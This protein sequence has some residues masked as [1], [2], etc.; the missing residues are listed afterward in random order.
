MPLHKIGRVGIVFYSEWEAN[1]VY[2]YL[3]YVRTDG[4][5]Y[6]C[7]AEH[8]SDEL[9]KPKDGADSTFWRVVVDNSTTKLELLQNIDEKLET[10]KAELRAYISE[11][12]A[13]L[14]KAAI[15]D[16]LPDT[17][18]IG[19]LYLV[20]NGGS[21]DNLYDEY[22]YI[23][24]G[25]EAEPNF[26]FEKLGSRQVEV[27]LDGHYDK[28]EID[29]ML[30]KMPKFA[31][32]LPNPLNVTLDKNQEL[33]EF[34]FSSIGIGGVESVSFGEQNWD[35]TNEYVY[36][37][38]QENKV[39]RKDYKA[40][41][42]THFVF[43][44]G[45]EKTTNLN[46]FKFTIEP[47]K[48]ADLAPDSGIIVLHLNQEL[49]TEF[50]V[51]NGFL[52]LTEFILGEQNWVV[53]WQER[54]GA[55]IEKTQT[56][57]IETTLIFEDG[58]EKV[59]VI[60]YTKT[61]REP[62]VPA[63]IVADELKSA[64]IHELKD[65]KNGTIKLRGRNWDYGRDQTNASW[66]YRHPNE[67]TVFGIDNGLIIYIDSIDAYSRKEYYE[68]EIKLNSLSDGN[69]GSIN[70]FAIMQIDGKNYCFYKENN[71]IK[72]PLDTLNTWKNLLETGVLVYA[73]GEYAYKL[74]CKFGEISNSGEISFVC[75]T[76]IIVRYDT[77][78]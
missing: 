73:D 20:A 26:V 58:S 36:T 13:N 78:G 72:E 21:D 48:F 60:N 54:Y 30:S 49:N 22:I 37:D 23:N 62:Y 32:F 19:M 71:D 76:E 74:S 3:D 66:V 75:D 59:I 35:K 38:E 70:G 53:I 4:N 67:R 17:G 42:E 51:S 47:P 55:E 10:T 11:V 29:E 61:T 45:S 28:N 40:L 50:F 6:M 33:N 68:N 16:T 31:D 14:N 7:V 56:A 46:C 1:R 39:L 64:I 27:N 43:K 9:N 8:L 65:T 52:G 5:C 25:S 44:D 12:M 15:V 24:K 63:N 77:V 2:S 34:D 69:W 18:E 41:V 57:D